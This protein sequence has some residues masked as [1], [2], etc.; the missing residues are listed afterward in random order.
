MYLACTRFF[1][2]CLVLSCLVLSC[3]ALPCL[4]LPCL[5]H[6]LLS[7]AFVFVVQADQDL[8]RAAHADATTAS[9]SVIVGNDSDFLLFPGCRYV[10]FEHWENV[11]SAQPVPVWTRR[12]LATVTGLSEPQLV[13]MAIL[14]G[15]DFTG[16]LSL[17][18]FHGA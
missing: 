9:S 4:A 2:P 18:D 10:T 1:F 3:L 7:F 6:C 12:Y 17:S 13:D 16:H 5:F 11:L 15:N 14:M 8:A